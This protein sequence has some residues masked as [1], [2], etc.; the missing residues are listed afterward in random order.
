MNPFRWAHYANIIPLKLSTFNGRV[1]A[2]RLSPPVIPSQIR[3]DK[4]VTTAT[5]S[6]RISN[7]DRD[8]SL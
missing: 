3:F 2:S 5:N 4:E 8:S 7:F 1:L 6:G